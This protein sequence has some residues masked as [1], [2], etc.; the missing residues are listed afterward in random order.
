M[1]NLSGGKGFQGKSLRSF[2]CPQCDKQRMTRPMDHV[3]SDEKQT[4]TDKDGNEIELL[5]DICEFCVKKNT[6]IHFMP[7]R[8][9]VKKVLKSMSEAAAAESTEDDGPDLESML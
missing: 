3:V 6:R 4:Y 1:R 2:F 7:T 8:A 9:D 5:K